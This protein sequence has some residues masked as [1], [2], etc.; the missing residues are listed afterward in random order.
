MWGE[1]A[2]PVGTALAPAP[3]TPLPPH[4]HCLVDSLLL[5]LRRLQYASHCSPAP[6]H[7]FS[8][9][10]PG[11][12]QRQRDEG[13]TCSKLEWLWL[14]LAESKLPPPPFFLRFH[15]L[16]AFQWGLASASLYG[17]ISH[18]LHLL[19]ISAAP[20]EHLPSEVQILQAHPSQP[21]LFCNIFP[22]FSDRVQWEERALESDQPG[23]YSYNSITEYVIWREVFN[24]PR[25][26]HV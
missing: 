21:C 15:I 18:H 22:F 14:F 2:G 11:R 23:F 16:E 6:L 19:P 1:L 9:R 7:L 12:S 13:V 5:S 24:L 3:A 10:P 17:P 20:W 26:P 25:V 8:T 4:Q